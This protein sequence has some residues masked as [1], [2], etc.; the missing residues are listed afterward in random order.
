[1]KKLIC[2]IMIICMCSISMIASAAVQ[3]NIKDTVNTYEGKEVIIK[4][5]G[6]LLDCDISPIIHNDR[7]LIPIRA[8]IEKLGG[9][10]T[11]DGILKLVTISYKGNTIGM[12]IGNNKASV[13]GI[14]T[15]MDVAPCIAY[16]KG[17]EDK[18][19][20]VLPIRFIMENFG[21]KVEWDQETYTVNIIYDESDPVATNPEDEYPE[22][23]D[24]PIA[25]EP[26]DETLTLKTTLGDIFEAEV[27]RIGLYFKDTAKRSYTV[28]SSTSIKIGVIENGEFIEKHVINPNTNIYLSVNGSYV[29]VKVD[30]IIL[31]GLSGTVQLIPE[32]NSNGDRV[33]YGNNVGYRGGIEVIRDG[34][35]LTI[36]NLI[37]MEEY[38]YAVVPSEM[39]VSFGLEALKAQ[40]ICAR[41]YAYA[42]ISRHWSDGFDLCT[43]VHCQA[44]HAICNEHYLSTQAVNE[45]KDI[46]VT[47][48]GELISTYYSS[49]MGPY[50]ED[51]K[52]VWSNSGIP[53]LVSVKN[54]YEPVI[55]PGVA[56][57]SNSN[58][59]SK[60]KDDG[61]NLGTLLKVEVE[62]YT[63]AQR[64]Y[65]LVLTGTNGTKTYWKEK[66]GTFFNLRGLMYK[67][68]GG[69]GIPGLAKAIQ[70][71]KYIV[72]TKEEVVDNDWAMISVTRTNA[73][74]GDVSETFEGW[75]SK[76]YIDI[77]ENDIVTVN[78]ESTLNLRAEPNT[79][80][81]VVAKITK[82]DTCKLL[83]SK[84]VTE[85]IIKNTYGRFAKITAEELNVRKSASTSADI[86]CQIGKNEGYIIVDE[87]TNWYKI[88]V[89]GDEGWISKS[90]ATEIKYD[91]D[92]VSNLQ[93]TLLSEGITFRIKITVYDNGH[94][95][96][97]SQYGA[98]GM[99]DA[100]FNCVDIL[101]FYFTGVEVG[102]KQ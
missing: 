97:M 68:D 100:G 14:Q 75:V 43:T 90:Y 96:G 72:E 6:E 64:A 41:T 77:G 102:V 29:Q 37:T 35:A 98:K 21:L 28:K 88:I 94:G 99:A 60:L 70:D 5:N 63:P 79:S 48:N 83:K 71:N 50:T 30:G 32:K 7:T 27:I 62:Q 55:E 12:C 57:F 25:V 3:F 69:E 44:Y 85:K 1:M 33:I 59:V 51:V 91:L 9:S 17:E 84:S 49:S 53:Y 19:R 73:E 24:N 15:E 20:T 52:N 81:S 18:G 39:Y 74:T 23:I 34:T 95:V 46:V 40:A 92:R 22:E 38:L 86:I 11:W 2:L 42:Q 65:K 13:N 67:I 47:Y 66:S 89:C 58:I 78:I 16:L 56:Y 26:D 54:I 93:S 31:D 45:T 82:E 87:T 76:K 61:A 10:V 8:V 80:C 101:K 36:V 4:Y